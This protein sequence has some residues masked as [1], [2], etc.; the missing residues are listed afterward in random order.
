[1][2]APDHAQEPRRWQVHDERLIFVWHLPHHRRTFEL[3]PAIEQRAGRG[4]NG[5]EI[6]RRRCDP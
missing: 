2:L 5:R 1:V 3:F 4:T 6:A